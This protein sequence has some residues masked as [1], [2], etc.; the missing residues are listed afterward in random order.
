MMI[1]Y[2]SSCFRGGDAR[3]R[4]HCGRIFSPIMFCSFHENPGIPRSFRT[5]MLLLRLPHMILR[6]HPSGACFLTM[7]TS[8]Y[9][10]L[11]L[12]SC[13][14]GVMSSILT[15]LEVSL[16]RRIVEQQPWTTKLLSFQAMAFVPIACRDI[17][18]IGAPW[19][20]KP[21]IRTEQSAS[22]YM[23]CPRL[24]VIDGRGGHVL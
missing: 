15:R 16:L 4:R 9:S 22:R 19:Y 11:G 18:F 6:H 10:L 2:D 13:I 20:I 24:R 8:S 12:F 23:T 14:T 1:K 17:A 7:T 21:V 3:H 5:W